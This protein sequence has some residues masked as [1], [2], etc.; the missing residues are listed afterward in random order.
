MVL[1]AAAVTLALGL[2]AAAE[3]PFPGPADPSSDPYDYTQLHIDNGSCDGVPT[4]DAVPA[5]ADLPSNFD[6]RDDWK[7]SDYR[8]VL[9]DDDYDPYIDANPQEF[10][11]VRGPGTNEAWET[12]TGRPDT[13]IAVTDS[14]IRWDEDRENLVNKFALNRGEL[15]VPGSGD[16]RGGTVQEYDTNGDG[17]FNVKDYVDAGDA[18]AV[19]DPD[20]DNTLLDPGDLVRAFSDGV[21]DDG[22]GYTDD[23]S[24]WDFFEGDN[25]PNDDVDY[26]HGTGESEDSAGETGIDIDPQCPNCMLMEMRVGDSFVADA[27]HFAEA[28]VYATDNGA[29]VIQSALGSLNHT[30]FAQAAADYAYERGVLFVASAADESAGH[31]N[32]PSALNHTMVVNSITHAA[33][34][35]GVPVQYPP[36]WLAFNGCTNFGGY[37]WVSVP[38]TSCSSDAVGQS[39]GMA[40]LLYSAARNAVDLGVID[41]DVSGKPLSAEEAKQ[42]F[43]LAAEDIDFSTP[44]P[45]GPPNNFFTT[46]PASQRFVTTAGWD[47]ISGWGRIRSDDMVAMV[48]AGHIPPEA[49]ITGPRWWAPLPAAGTVEVTGRVAA[50]RA[51]AYTYEV[52]WAPGVQPPKYPATDLETW[53]TAAT[54]SGATATEGVLATLDLAEVR[55]AIETNQLNPA[56][57]PYTPADDPTARSMPEQDAFR[58]RVI[59]HADGDTTAPWKTAIAQH[60]AFAHDDPA[61]LAGWPRFLEADG[62]GSPAFEDLDADGLDELIIGDGNGYVH[63]YKADGTEAAGWPVHTSPINLPST[64]ENGYTTGGMPGT[65]YGALLTG[66]PLVADLDRNGTPEVSVGDVE[67]NLHVWT[68]TGQPVAGFP[69]RGIP[70]Y[71]HESQ[72]QEAPDANCDDDGANDVRDELNTTDQAFTSQPAAGDLDPSS[73]GLELVAGSN[74]GHVYA[75]HSDGSPVDGWPVLLR[76]PEKVAAVDPVT[77]LVTYVD[78]SGVRFGRKVLPTPSIGD[79]DG[80]GDLEV[81]ANVN[82]EYEET[83]NSTDP[84]I[85][86]LAQ[87]NANG[88]TRTYLLHHDGSAH[89]PSAATDATP[90]PDDQAYVAGWPV[91]VAMLTLE[92]LPYVGEGSNGTPVMADTDDDGS[93]EI[94]TASIASPPY[95][96]EPDGSST[97]GEAPDGRY[98]TGASSVPGAGST[99]TDLPTFASLGGGVFGHV[100]GNPQLGF[101]MGSTGVKRLLDVIL[102]EQ[103]LGAED[104][105]SVWDPTLGQFQPGYPAQMNDLQFINAPVI[106]DVTGDGMAEVLQS[107]AMYDLQGYGAAGLP[108]DGFP[109]LTGGWSVA[110]AGAGDLDG[111]GTLE[112]ALSTREGNLFLWSTAGATCQPVEW[113]KNGHDLHNSGNYATDADRPGPI[114][115]VTIERVGDEIVVRFTGSGDDGTCGSAAGYR[116]TAGD[117]VVDAP[118]GATEVRLP[119][120]GLPAGT[121][122]SVQGIDDVGNIGFAGTAVLDAVTTPNA[123]VEPVVPAGPAATPP[124]RTLPATGGDPAGALP[125]LLLGLAVAGRSAVR[126][127]PSAQRTS[128]CSPRGV[129]AKP[130]NG[131]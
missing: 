78:G 46:L 56:T 100:G 112:L 104:H 129:V 12:T 128:T 11:G 83:P 94:G 97:L 75:W 13:V 119:A 37:I 116:I 126:R 5:G 21:D 53:T 48:A 50:P 123:P 72:C 67:G 109:K 60:Q 98:I 87:V 69:V 82:E 66:A 45:P 6:C 51:A 9:G 61:L 95:F 122:V 39:A 113:P 7:L 18:R 106:L 38:S 15:P 55:A 88:N 127:V 24:G 59:T 8:A 47:Q 74:D 58:I 32:Q 65:V 4:G 42:L 17:V 77:H 115:D 43:R 118:A 54:G 131:S 96:L 33:D 99:S 31:H 102:P 125:L 19:D 108:A 85:A 14:G 68:H 105:I 29:S 120:A 36:T 3:L 28:A 76:D 89:P 90:N 86:A 40:G 92:L 84:A 26:G 57:A 20:D 41:P 10:N 63:A 35:E 93:L 30:R 117:V 91:P 25:D 111:D 23:V 16:D 52:Q 62:A 81:A 64:G 103:Q 71:S 1:G 124:T 110:S 79:V 34:V 70:E 114:F 80:D 101:A 49:D 22:N 73:P 107:S 27:N 121:V 2:P 130:R 44:K